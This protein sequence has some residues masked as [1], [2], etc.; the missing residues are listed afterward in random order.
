MRYSAEAQ[1]LLL[2]AAENARVLGHSYVGSAHLLLALSTDPG[3]AGQMLRFA[4]GTPELLQKMA[5]VL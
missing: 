5:S 3:H 4:G 1:R 2:R